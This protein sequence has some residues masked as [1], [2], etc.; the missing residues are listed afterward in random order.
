MD[1]SELTALIEIREY[2]VNAQSLP[3]VDR[4]K[5]NQLTNILIL[6]DNKIIDLLI[7]PDFKQYVGY[8]NLKQAK[9]AAIKTNNIYSGIVIDPHTKLKS[10]E[11]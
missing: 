10:R 11:K 7:A 6:L 2:V 4:A 3:T 5:C 8:D 1:L 9:Q